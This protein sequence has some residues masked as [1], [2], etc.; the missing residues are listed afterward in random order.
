MKKLAAPWAWAKVSAHIYKAFNI[1]NYVK[2]EGK[3]FATDY[4]N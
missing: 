1:G 3:G 4:T 2:E